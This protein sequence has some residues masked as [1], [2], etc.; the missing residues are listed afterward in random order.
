MGSL[1]HADIRARRI[2][3]G[4][5]ASRSDLKTR[6][7]LHV[8]GDLVDVRVRVGDPERL[9]RDLT[10]LRRRAEELRRGCVLLDQQVR[11]DEKRVGRLF[12]ATR[13]E[14]EIDVGRV[15]SREGIGFRVDLTPIYEVVSGRTE[16]DIDRAL[17]EFYA[18][19]I[20]G[21]LTR[22]NR[23]TIRKSP[24]N[25]KVFTTVLRK[26]HDLIF[27][28]READKH[29]ARASRAEAD[30]GNVLDEAGASSPAV[31]VGGAALPDLEIEFALPEIDHGPGD[32]L[33][34][35]TVRAALALRHGD[36][37]ALRRA[38]LVDAR[39]RDREQPVS[40]RDLTHIAFRAEDGE[41]VWR[42]SGVP[43]DRH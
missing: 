33:D 39:G 43:P 19:A 21:S 8:F 20:V 32:L 17:L 24:S 3:V 35:R 28:A 30:Y 15:L 10:R 22:L 37:P 42:R 13:I 11:M 27:L 16:S 5:A 6:Q 29:E 25:R 7:G 9:S 23:D 12:Q 36:G 40:S 34:V 14:C 4:K 2:S 31:S 41:V 18:K 26:L 38:F 1:R